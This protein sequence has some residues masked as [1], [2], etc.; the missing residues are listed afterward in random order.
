LLGYDDNPNKYRIEEAVNEV[1]QIKML[2]EK[3]GFET[4]FFIYP[5]FYKTYVL[6]NQSRMKKFKSAL[7]DITDFYDFYMLNDTAFDELQWRDTSHFVYS[8]AK[9]MHDDIIQGKYRVTKNTIKENLKR[10][11]MK[12]RRLLQK[13]FPIPYILRLHPNFYIPGLKRVWS[14]EKS[15][16][17]TNT[18]LTITKTKSGY[19]LNA[20]GNDPYFFINGIKSSSQ[21]ILFVCMIE[22]DEKALFQLFFKRKKE[23]NWNERDS[24]K[25]FLHQG[26]NTIRL[27]IPS[28]FLR[29]G[30]RID[31]INRTGTYRVEKCFIAEL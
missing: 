8:V 13:H 4:V 5:S 15:I 26:Q 3:Y 16:G 9:K 10:I 27:V 7:A 14:L 30:L 6:Y 21:N 20:K 17:K 1:R 28:V 22:T 31:P 23:E 12:H 19:M 11:E 18:M 25:V 29:Y 2:G 24:F